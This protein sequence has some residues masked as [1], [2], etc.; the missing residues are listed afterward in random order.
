MQLTVAPES[1]AA[2]T[3]D[4]TIRCLLDMRYP[5][6]SRESSAAIAFASQWAKELSRAIP[7]ELRL[8]QGPSPATSTDSVIRYTADAQLHGVPLHRNRIWVCFDLF[9][10]NCKS[11]VRQQVDKSLARPIHA[12]VSMN[13]ETDIG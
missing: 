8:P 9:L 13:R 6:P 2:L 11:E 1:S 5:L 7:T 4:G 10:D 12:I 3:T